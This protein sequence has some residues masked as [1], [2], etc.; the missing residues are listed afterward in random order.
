MIFVVAGVL[1]VGLLLVLLAQ[2]QTAESR[3]ADVEVLQ[4]SEGVTRFAHGEDLP[5]ELVYD[6]RVLMEAGR[7]IDAVKRVREV[8]HWGLKEAKDYVESLGVPVGSAFYS[9]DVP[10]GNASRPPM[11]QA[12]IP[13]E[14]LGRVQDLLARRQKIEAIKVVREVTNWGL[15]ETKDYVDSMEASGG[16]APYSDSVSYGSTP[17]V[18]T[19]QTEI[20]ADVM[21]KVQDLLARRQKIEAIKVVREV[22]NWGL[23]EAK[24]FV[25]GLETSR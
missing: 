4:N 17:R 16:L 3:K 10:Y 21:R 11:A 8:T 24:D 7:E 15:K 14:V 5:P 6:V 19:S 20:P 2:R 23:K 9:S 18:P 25:D 13:A 22:T 1:V 12:N